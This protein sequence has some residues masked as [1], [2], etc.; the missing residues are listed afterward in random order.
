MC[1]FTAF[2]RAMVV[3]KIYVVTEWYTCI[4]NGFKH[5]EDKKNEDN[6][7]NENNNK[8]SNGNNSSSNNKITVMK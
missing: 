1:K 5:E 8:H 6:S 3:K 2:G 7:N 4:N